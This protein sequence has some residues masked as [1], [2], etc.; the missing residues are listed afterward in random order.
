MEVALQSGATTASRQGQRFE[1][2]LLG[3]CNRAKSRG[4]GRGGE[5]GER[6]KKRKNYG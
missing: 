3:R 5:G 1:G 4:K 6:K 2:Q